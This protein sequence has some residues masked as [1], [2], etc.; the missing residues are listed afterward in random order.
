MKSPPAFVG[1]AEYRGSP[2]RDPPTAFTLTHRT[3]RSPP[4][5]ANLHDGDAESVCV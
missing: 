3:E 2:K 5:F 1:C 4:A